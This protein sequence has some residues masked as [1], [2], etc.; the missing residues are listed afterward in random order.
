MDATSSVSGRLKRLT[1][2]KGRFRGFFGSCV[3][4]DTVHVVA[5]AAEK[6]ITITNEAQTVTHTTFD[7]NTQATS[8]EPDAASAHAML[9]KSGDE[10][11]TVAAAS[12]PEQSSWMEAF[13][14]AGATIRRATTI[15]PTL[16][17]SF[18]ELESYD[19]QGHCVPM[20]TY[21]GRLNYTQLVELDNKYRDRGLQILA[22]PC[23]QF[24]GQEPGTNEE[25][26]AFVAGFNATFPFFEKADVNG[27]NTQP[28]YAYLKSKLTGTLGS[29]IKWNFTKFL[30]DRN[31]QPFKRYSPQTAP[32][33]FEADILQLLDQAQ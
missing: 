2:D 24:G 27:D 30:V 31:G 23:N 32:M 19:M 26:M 20:E 9:L 3:K 28:V 21:R 18:F 29:A 10:R 12:A 33:D 14:R 16:A 1:L 17:K 25:I 6:K 13:Q 4:T 11:V 7:C 22:Y 8:V 15:D 5:D